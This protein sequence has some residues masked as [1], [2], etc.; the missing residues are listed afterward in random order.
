MP[1]MIGSNEKVGDSR[2]DPTT[3]QPA[4]QPTRNSDSSNKEKKLKK[5]KIYIDHPNFWIGA[6]GPSRNLYW[7]YDALRFLRV[8]VDHTRFWGADP[9]CDVTA[10]VYGSALWPFRKTWAD[11][12]RRVNEFVRSGS[13]REK[14]V[15]TSLVAD[16]VAEAIS[17]RFHDME[18]EFVIVSG[19]RDM[20]PAVKKIMDCKFR[21][22]VW[23][24]NWTVSAAYTRLHEEH[25]ARPFDERLFTLYRLDDF[26]GRFG[27]RLLQLAK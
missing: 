12:G 9:K 17:D 24:W 15:D 25:E 26:M 16:V 11:L 7:V 22:Y 2:E 6:Q 14:E 21:V 10:D 3:T 1:W 27:Y 8:L 4:P 23:S 13:N 5:I 20:R 18:T 19:D